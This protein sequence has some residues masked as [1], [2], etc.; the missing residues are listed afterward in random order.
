MKDNL[1]E[2]ARQD[3]QYLVFWPFQ[4]VSQF[5]NKIT[6]IMSWHVYVCTFL[7]SS[8]TAFIIFRGNDVSKTLSHCSSHGWPFNGT[9]TPLPVCL[10][11]FE[12]LVLLALNTPIQ[13]S[14]PTWNGILHEAFHHHVSPNLSPY[15][16]SL[17]H[18]FWGAQ[19][20]PLD[21]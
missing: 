13:F 6:C 8:S 18:I 12:C 16:F 2:W 1:E 19:Y 17:R 5:P 9:R 10:C 21:T 14:R 20:T 15:P 11:F 3:I 4:G 7:G